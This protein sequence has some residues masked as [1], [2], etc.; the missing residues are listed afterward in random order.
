MHNVG[1]LQHLL[2]QRRK[3]PIGGVGVNKT[4]L[5]TSLEEQTLTFE[6]LEEKKIDI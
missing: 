2:T 6:R 4:S 5:E 3:N 1:H